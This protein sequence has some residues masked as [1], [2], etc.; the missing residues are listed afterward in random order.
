LLPVVHELQRRGWASKRWRTRKGHE[1]GGRPF[2]KT[3]LYRLLTNVIYAGQARYKDEVHAGEQPA[4]ID[5]DTFG[6]VQA[7]LRRHGPAVGAPAP[8]RQPALL[9]GLLR[10]APC[11]CAMTPSQTTRQRTRRYRYYVCSAAQKRGWHSCPSKSV[12]AGQIERLV[13][14]Q[15][16]GLGRDP[17]LLQQVLAEVRSHDE[18]RLAELDGERRALE[19]ELCRW[20]AEVRRLLAPVGAEEPTGAAL[21]RLAELQGRMGQVEQRVARLRDQAEALRQQQRE[22]AELTQA[23]AGLDPCGAASGPGEQARLVRLLVARVDYDG[24]RGKV[25]ITFRPQGLKTL[26]GELAGRSAE[27]DIA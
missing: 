22:Q 23:L 17:A 3:S 16:Q 7:L 15:V 19:H 10:C 6:R 13:L 11:G 25:S 2:T 9:R 21:S 14:E 18:V 1:R 26:A 4:L 5:P 20:H 27:E 8:G 12:P 24:V